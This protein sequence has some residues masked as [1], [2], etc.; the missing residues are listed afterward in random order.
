VYEINTTDDF[1]GTYREFHRLPYAE[2]DGLHRDPVAYQSTWCGINVVTDTGEYWWGQ[3]L[4]S[5]DFTL[6]ENGEYTMNVDWKRG[7][8][9]Y[10]VLN[11]DNHNN[12]RFYSIDVHHILEGLDAD[13]VYTEDKEKI[14]L[15][16]NQNIHAYHSGDAFT[17]DDVAMV[18]NCVG[19]PEGS[20]GFYTVKVLTDGIE[21]TRLQTTYASY[22]VN[23]STE[24]E[25]REQIA[26][27]LRTI[28]VHSKV[29]PCRAAG[30]AA[31]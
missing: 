18:R 29:A 30:R 26:T 22:F 9:A 17:N 24:F 28:R 27:L 3:S 5:R 14:I 21:L 12:G 13:I 19:L 6:D 7:S 23:S 11:P 15:T 25:I 31:K 10:W 20:D 16:G 8:N 1:H 2:Y 4:H